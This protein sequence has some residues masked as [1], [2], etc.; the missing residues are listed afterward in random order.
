MGE[1]GNIAINGVY[2]YTHWKG[3]RLKSILKS[4][5]MRGKSRWD[6]PPY[7]ARIIFCEMMDGD[8][9]LT[10]YGISTEIEDNNHNAFE[11]DTD[12]QA[13]REHKIDYS[14]MKLGNIVNEWT[15]EDF[16]ST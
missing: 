11:V 15:F 8:N 10:G 9:G 16:I 4:A 1:R 6:D 12:K 7:L 5:L 2:L 14:E 13:V 3:H